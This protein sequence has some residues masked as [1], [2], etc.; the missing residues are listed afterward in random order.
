MKF[1]SAQSLFYKSKDNAKGACKEMLETVLDQVHASI[2]TKQSILLDIEEEKRKEYQQRFAIKLRIKPSWIYGDDSLDKPNAAGKKC[3]ISKN[4]MS[5]GEFLKT[6]G[7]SILKRLDINPPQHKS[8]ELDLKSFSSHSQVPPQKKKG[9]FIAKSIEEQKEI[10]MK[11]GGFGTAKEEFIK[12]MNKKKN[13]LDSYF[14]GSQ[15]N[16]PKAREEEQ[17]S[18]LL[19]C[20]KRKY[21]PPFRKKEAI[22][23]NQDS[24]KQQKYPGLDDQM[25]QIIEDEIVDDVGVNWNDIAGLSDAKQTIQ[26]IIVW[27]LMRSDLF[28]G[29]KAPPKGLLLFGPP[30]TGKTMLGRAI[31]TQLNCTF[32]SISSSMI[33]S[34]WVGEAEKMV[35][36]LFKLAVIKQ[37]SV[38]FIDEIDSLLCARSDKDMESSRRL[39]TEFLINL[40]G[41]KSNKDDRVLLIG[42]TNRPEELDEAA[43][44]RFVKRLYIPLPCSSAR[45]SL[46]KS[47]IEKERL[48]GSRYN[49][50]ENEIIEIVAKT[51]GYSAADLQNLMSETAM[52]PLREVSDILNAKAEDLRPVN[53]NDFI[54]SIK[55]TKSSVA[56]EELQRY[57][58]WNR[59]FGS[60]EI[61]DID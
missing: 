47:V 34:K 50:S 10:L 33:T 57:R 38:V 17:N 22:G 25:V 14:G 28:K 29:A 26:E 35:K 37:P 13:N 53:L 54:L 44:R 46:I 40:D 23:D 58:D 43:R 11:H 15:H 20:S 42:A 27:P 8:S 49:I 45:H 18:F 59:Q 6:N 41:A 55:R 4:A 19:N 21:V 61:S 16:S 1:N 9:K 60:F 32:F 3:N 48:I 12:E 36:T 39:K 56:D 30:G 52:A 5:F 24:K 31:A 7:R 2:R 51:K